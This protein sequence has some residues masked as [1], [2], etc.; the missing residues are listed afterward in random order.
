[1]AEPIS[2]FLQIHHYD[3]VLVALQD[4]PAGT[5]INFHELNF[6]LQTAVSAKHKFTM[7]DL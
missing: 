3:N 5:A 2:K 6:N 1:M 7:H 4:L